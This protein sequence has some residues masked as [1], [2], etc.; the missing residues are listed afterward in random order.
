LCPGCCG[1]CTC[2]VCYPAV[3]CF[4]QDKCN[5]GVVDT[6]S[7]CCRTEPVVCNAG[8][9]Q[10][11]T[12]LP[13]SGCSV[14]NVTCK[15]PPPG[16]C[17]EWY[18]NATSVNCAT[19]PLSPLPPTCQNIVIPQCVTDGDCG[20]RSKCQNDTCVNGTCVH[21]QVVCPPSDQCQTTVC[22]PTAGCVTTTKICND[23][24]LCTND[25]CDPVFPGGCV[26]T[27][28][29]CPDYKDP[30]LKTYCDP[31]NGCLNKTDVKELPVCNNFTAG[32]C[33]QVKCAN[34]TCFLQY[35]CLTPPPTSSES[36]PTNT[37]ILASSIT[38]AAIAGIVIA[39]A[40]LVIGL[41]GGAAVAIAG[42][43]GAGGVVSVQS[44]PLYSG[45]GTSGTNPL[46][47]DK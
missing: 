26:Y 5:L 11:A 22:K 43:A 19:R 46:A 12:C 24:N 10:S 32:N 16:A 27:N 30:C 34:K 25:K 4:D 23:N 38:G 37:V 8:P 41:G 20:G 3:K 45:A 31:L 15:P 44:N 35:Y 21:K 1:I 28:V 9:C 13:A 33:S 47:Q 40:V 42:A 29:T 14:A 6:N 18:C 36:F 2:G 17:Y 39:G 7:Q